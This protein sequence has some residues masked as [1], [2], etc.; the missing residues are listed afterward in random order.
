MHIAKPVLRLGFPSENACQVEH[1][2]TSLLALEVTEHVLELASDEVLDLLGELGDLLGKLVTLRVDLLAGDLGLRLDLLEHGRAVS[3]LVTTLLD[4]GR[5][6]GLS[7]TVPGE[8]VGSVAGDIGKSTNSGNRDESSLE[9]LGADISDSEGRVL[10]GLEGKKVGE[11]TSNV[12]RS[13]R[14]TGDGVDGVLAANPGGLDV[15]TGSKDVVALAVVGEVGALVSESAGTNGDGVLSGSRR[16]VARVS[17]VVTGG[18]SEVDTGIDSSVDS[19]VKDGGFATAQAHVGS[20][21]LEALS[22][23]LLGDADLL[24]VR[25]GGVLNTLDDVGHGARAVGAEDLDGLDVS[26]LGDTVLLAGDSARAVCSVSVAILICITLRNGLAP[27]C[28]TLEVDVVNV[29]AGVDDVDVN[30][31]TTVLGVEVLVEGAEAQAVAVGDTG[32]TPGS[33]LLD[34]GL[35]LEHVDLLISLDEFDL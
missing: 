17:V 1:K 10:G 32:E 18:N 9:L 8:D 11:E 30:T 33:V 16:V 31:L 15:K 20:G 7:A 24:E 21:A 2:A 3:G 35:R 14:G 22:L 26:L 29:G 13:H 27:R 6:V 12:G 23:A 28:A 4:N 34:L 25:L 19:L 5:V